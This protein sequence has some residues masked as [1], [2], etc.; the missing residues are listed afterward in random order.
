MTSDKRILTFNDF[1]KTVSGRYQSHDT[2]LYKPV[3]EFL[4]QGFNGSEIYN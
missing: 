1:E 2:H 4:G 3:L